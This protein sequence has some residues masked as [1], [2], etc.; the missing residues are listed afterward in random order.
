MVTTYC[1]HRKPAAAK[2]GDYKHRKKDTWHNG[3]ASSG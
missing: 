3:P 1:P 2:Q